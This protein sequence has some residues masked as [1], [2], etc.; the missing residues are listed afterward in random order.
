MWLAP[1]LLYHSG[2][3]GDA[4]L[5]GKAKYPGEDQEE[6]GHLLAEV[7][8]MAKRVEDF[9]VTLQGEKYQAVC[10]RCHKTPEKTVCEPHAADKLRQPVT[11]T[12]AGLQ[13]E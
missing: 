6:P 12:E 1:A 4:Y 8:A 11:E 2:R 9:E 3:P 7:L 10:G 13:H 5:E